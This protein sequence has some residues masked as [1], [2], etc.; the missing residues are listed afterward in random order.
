[1]VKTSWELT[2]ARLVMKEWLNEDGGVKRTASPEDK[3]TLADWLEV[4]QAGGKPGWTAPQR[5][6]RVAS[7]LTEAR[8]ALRK[9]LRYVC[10]FLMEAGGAGV[11]LLS[12]LLP[13]HWKVGS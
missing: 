9:E 8:K 7:A 10:A 13:R 11:A 4:P 12:R 1:M 3:D 2:E 5:Q 6:A